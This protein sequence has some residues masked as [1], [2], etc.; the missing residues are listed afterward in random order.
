VF[1]CNFLKSSCLFCYVRVSK[2]QTV[3]KQKGVGS[4][5]RHTY[6]PLLFCAANI[7]AHAKLTHQLQLVRSDGDCARPGVKVDIQSRAFDGCAG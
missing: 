7:R 1:G 4:A 2:K 6:W 5:V 3:I